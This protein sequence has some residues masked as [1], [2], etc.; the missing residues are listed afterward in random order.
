MGDRLKEA[1]FASL[2]PQLRDG[3]FLDL[4]A[5][6]G[7]GGI[8]ALSRGASSVTFVERQ[9]AALDAIE[10]NLAATHLAG[11]A[12]RVVAG[13]AIE[14]LLRGPGSTAYDVVFADPPYDRPDLLV[15]AIRR[16]AERGPDG[17]LASDGVLVAK[18]PAREGLERR[19]GLLASGR[20][21][22]FGESGLT[23]YAWETSEADGAEREGE[24]QLR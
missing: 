19:F 16:I 18:H 1:L 2:E 14:W 12:A 10:R 8:E 24:T 9:A 13:D 3:A 15:G 20:E 7:A 21:R 4:F 23:L 11:P 6:T 5:G 22:R 17:W